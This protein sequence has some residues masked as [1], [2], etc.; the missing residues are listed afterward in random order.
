[1][2]K[3]LGFVAA[4]AFLAASPAFA[5][6]APPVAAA[7]VV[8]HAERPGARI[9]PEIFGQF[10]EHLGSGIYGGIWVGKDSPIP[11]TNGYRNDVLAA[12]KELHV[13]VVRWPGGCFGDEYHWRDGIGPHRAVTVNT[14]WGGVPE[15]NTFGTHEFLDFVE[16]IGAKA[17]ISANVGTGTPRE[18]ADWLAYITTTQD[19]TLARLRRENGRDK[20]WK[21]DYFA[22]GNETWGC[23]GRMRP[24][25]YADQYRQFATFLKAP[26]GAKPLLIASGGY[27]GHPEWTRALIS[28][29]RGNMDAISFHYYTLPN[30]KRD[31]DHKGSATGFPESEWISTLVSALKLEGYLKENI[32]I[33]NKH[34]PQKKVGLFVDEWGTWY[35]PAPGSNPGFLVQQNSVRDAVVAGISLNILQSH[36][37]RVRMANIAQM[38][39]VLQAMI[40]TDGPR[41]LLTPTYHVF[42]MYIPF[43]GATLLP[44]DLKT[45]RYA[46]GKLSVP[47]VSVS[48]ARGKDGSLLYALVNLDP[49]RAQRVSTAIVGAR[50]RHV[51]GSIL[52]G[53]TMDAHNTFDAP[54]TVKPAPFGGAT[55]RGGRLDVVLPPRSVVVLTL[56]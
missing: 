8:I 33:M 56:D 24:E 11:N 20:P 12:L 38:I 43:Q 54:D 5:A 49:R 25:Y 55:L 7:S 15:P 13:P 26:P 36:A 41:M 30:L 35:D 34:D 40:L 42:R 53:S 52:A 48:A 9:A 4:F 10:A 27:D 18:A 19:T 22:L 37:D 3:R 39:N 45:P 51:V 47:A 46:Q 6:K 29:V 32:A 1:M 21:L 44:V 14:N 16:M 31:W 28:T 23:G 2:L 17:Y 50:P